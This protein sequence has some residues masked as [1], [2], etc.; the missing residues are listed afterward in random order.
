MKIFTW[1]KQ[2]LILGIM[3]IVTL[4]SVACEGILPQT[5]TQAPQQILT[6]NTRNIIP[7]TGEQLSMG[8]TGKGWMPSMP[9]MEGKTPSVPPTQAPLKIALLLPLTGEYSKLGQQ[10]LDAAQLALFQFGDPGVLLVPLDTG[11]SSFDAVKAAQQAADGGAKL[12]LG[13]VFSQSTTAIMPI[14]KKYDIPVISFSNDKSL[15]GTGAF[16]LGMQ[17]EQQIHKIVEYAYQ[18][19][20]IAG[21]T[22]ILPNNN[23]G[24]AASK[25]LR[26]TLARFPGTAILRNEIYRTDA[27]NHVIG[28]TKHVQGAYETAAGGKNYQVRALLLPEGAERVLPIADILRTYPFDGSKVQLLGSSQWYDDRLLGHEV[29]EGAIFAAPPRENHQQFVASFEQTYQ[30]QPSAISSLAYD[31]IALVVTLKRLSQDGNIQ[32]HILLDR[33]GFTGIDGVFRFR[34][35]GICERALA[36]MQIRGG[37][38]IEL[39]PAPQSF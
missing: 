27:R 12:I 11:A 25:E 9:F 38:F 14:A 31:G 29:L 34:N 30:Y 4:S 18:Q 24:A 3:A 13:P 5:F 23:L 6:P 21:Y 22:A 8:D 39:L 20:Q 17:P 15:A 7:Q 36:I 35:D 2:S 32:Q 1:L 10:L 16:I 19:K 28:L 33:R 26:L 37:S